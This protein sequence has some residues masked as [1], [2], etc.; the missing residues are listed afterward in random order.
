MS[1]VIAMNAPTTYAFAPVF[2]AIAIVVSEILN[3]QA[4]LA[5]IDAKSLSSLT[6]H[7]IGL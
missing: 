5:D 2:Q 7:A 3:D 1:P 6:I 4:R